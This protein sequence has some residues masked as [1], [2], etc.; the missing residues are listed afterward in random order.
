MGT[1]GVKV[2]LDYLFVAIFDC[3]ILV[4]TLWKV[5]S[6][7][8]SGLT[9]NRLLS[10]LYRDGIVYFLVLFL[11]SITNVFLL[12]LEHAS[13]YFNFLVLFQRIMIAILSSRIII[14]V[15]KAV[16]STT[17]DLA[18]MSVDPLNFAVNENGTQSRSGWRPETHSGGASV[19]TVHGSVHRPVDTDGIEMNFL[20]A[21]EP[22]E[23]HC[24]CFLCV[25]YPTVVGEHRGA[26]GTV[27]PIHKCINRTAHISSY[28]G[29]LRAQTTRH[30]Y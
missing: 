9:K 21:S 23:G 29:D 18:T 13:L 2:W 25:S 5:G 4:L 28:S 26:V 20:I 24:Q 6:Q 16:G 11:V 10:T 22:Q 14:N 7:W 17:Y 1:D 27:K 19:V 12:N 30:G 15:R 3:N 8:K